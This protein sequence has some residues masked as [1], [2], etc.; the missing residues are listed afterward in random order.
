[1]LTN[2]I[3]LYFKI[4]KKFNKFK[5]NKY[6]KILK[7]YFHWYWG[8][9]MKGKFELINLFD[10]DSICSMVK[11]LPQTIGHDLNSSFYRGD[12]RYTINKNDNSIVLSCSDGREFKIKVNTIP[13]KN[14]LGCTNYID[15]DCFYK[16]SDNASLRYIKGL[17]NTTFD[18][19]KDLE[20]YRLSR[21]AFTNFLVANDN[22][23]DSFSS[24]TDN[25]IDEYTISTDYIKYRGY[26]IS[27]DCSNIISLNEKRVPS[28]E[29]LDNYDINEEKRIFYSIVNNSNLNPHTK[30]VLKNNFN[31]EEL[32]SYKKDIL[33][34]YNKLPSIKKAIEF[35]ECLFGN[36][37]RKYL[38]TNDEMAMFD[39]V[40]INTYEGK[41]EKSEEEIIADGIK[42]FVKTIYDG[43]DE[44]IKKIIG[45]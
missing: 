3:L 31:E 42:V 5:N 40:L 9:S 6:F 23:V 20:S 34:V 33:K 22:Y 19:L 2:K 25:K 37:I 15:I 32:L 27:R 24:F 17:E 1:M 41:L 21:K 28:K 45:Q 14:E 13:V 43:A 18:D 36:E 35:K 39:D 26:L 11:L 4:I 8:L 29:S 38:F 7:N 12:K 16:I 10:L 44:I 30:E